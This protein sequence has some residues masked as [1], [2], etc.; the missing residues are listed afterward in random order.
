MKKLTPR[1]KRWLHYRQ[2]AKRKSHATTAVSVRRRVATAWDGEEY[3][4]VAV[5]RAPI[6]PVSNLCFTKNYDLTADFLAN[7][8]KRLVDGAHLSRRSGSWIGRTR[9]S[10]TPFL[11]TYYDFSRIENIST[12]ASVVIAA[13]YE[14]GRLIVGATPPAVN[15]HKWSAPAFH[16]LYQMGF[17]KAVGLSSD[18]EAR[19]VSD[20]GEITMQI[21]SGTV[22]DSLDNSANA[23]ERLLAEHFHGTQLAELLFRI[24]TVVSEALTN[25]GHW[26]YPSA[27]REDLKRWWFAAT[28][29]PLTRSLAVVVYDQG[30]TI[31]T[32][33]PERPWFQKMTNFVKDLFGY[34]RN[35]ANWSDSDWIAAALAYGRTRSRKDYRGKGLPQM[36]QLVD[37]CEAGSLRIV[38]G[39]GSCYLE[40]GQQMVKEQ[41]AA[42]GI[43]GT[44]IEWHL[45]LP[46]PVQQ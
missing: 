2:A 32:S 7:W 3:V 29:S 10:K 12:A 33:L 26:A 21:V 19:F 28:L 31:P 8:Q 34:D 25:V 15:L 40:K 45:T 30:I 44:L 41:P 22:G 38:S 37:Q 1:F 5:L 11:Q 9:G 36:A 6:R 39:A 35:E 46:S 18:Q 27:G 16:K 20:D 4:Q 42:R 43:H 17:F 14:R 13:E 24:N 23:L